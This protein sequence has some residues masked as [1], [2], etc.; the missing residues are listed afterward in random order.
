M[1]PSIPL[2]YPPFIPEPPPYEEL[3]DNDLSSDSAMGLRPAEYRFSEFRWGFGER[4]IFL[5]TLPKLP[6]K[7][8]QC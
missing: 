6:G 2:I 1:C 5:T 8:R 4:L 3:L 7:P